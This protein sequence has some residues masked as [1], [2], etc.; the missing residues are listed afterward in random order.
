MTNG[1]RAKLAAAMIVG[2]LVVLTAVTIGNAES[3]ISD[4]AA[5][6]VHETKGHIW[7][8]Q[9]TSVI[10]WVTV[11]PAIWLGVAKLRPP[12]LRWSVVVLAVL[13]GSFLAS[14]WHIAV[15]IGLRK[16]AY[17]AEG[18]TYHFQGHLADPFLYELRKDVATY[19][20][21]VF[22][23]ILAQWL[24]GKA[25]E[26]LRDTDPAV[27]RFIHLSEGTVTH[28]IPVDEIEHVEAA[29]NYVEVSLGQ[30]QILHRATLAR[31]QE[32]LGSS[33]ARI[34]R[35]RIVRQGAVRRVTTDRSGDFEVT[36]ASGKVLRGS[37]RYRVGITGG[38]SMLGENALQAWDQGS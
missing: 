11:T 26:R 7:T 38:S 36:L 37:R 35:S 14:A 9:V 10:A 5:A 17:A 12:R 23:A 2:F 22:L 1:G 16:A 32:E 29:G 13:L 24:L 4:F 20:Q 19:L 15:M 25:D 31:V 27:H 3:M 21:F 18:A 34:H 30:R 33:F 8:W 6:G 28:R